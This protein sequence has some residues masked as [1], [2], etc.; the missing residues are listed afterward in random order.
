MFN[1]FAAVCPN[2]FEMCSVRVVYDRNNLNLVECSHNLV[3]ILRA[4]RSR[5]Y[6][7]HMYNC[8]EKELKF[9]Q[10]TSYQIVHTPIEISRRGFS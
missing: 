2:H 4:S 1:F 10:G 5:F 9:Y 7:K 6:H 8:R 3:E